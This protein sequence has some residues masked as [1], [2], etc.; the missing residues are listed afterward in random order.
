MENIALVEIQEE[1]SEDDL[2]IWQW[3]LL[4]SF[5]AVVN[6][7]VYCGQLALFACER[8]ARRSKAESRLLA[9]DSAT[10]TKYKW[11]H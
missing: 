7:L 11:F 5:V 6:L 10:T 1:M 3:W 4:M 9:F 8:E 2:F